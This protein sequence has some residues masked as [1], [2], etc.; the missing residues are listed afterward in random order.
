MN[1]AVSLISY[2][3]RKL[4]DYGLIEEAPAQGKDG[5]E[6]WWRPASEGLSFRDEDFRDAPEAVATHAA[7]G[8]MSFEQRSELYRSFLDSRSAWAPDWRGA[9][10]SSEY[11]ARLTAGEL[12]ELGREMHALVWRY[13]EAGRAAV[14]AGDTAELRTEAARFGPVRAVTRTPGRLRGRLGWLLVE[15]GLRLV[16]SPRAHA[17]RTA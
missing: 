2:H 5:R 3:L 4:A 15:V 7:V 9:S 13:E 17:A 11:L 12:A 8:R 16:H 14:K 1:E 10:F 6:R